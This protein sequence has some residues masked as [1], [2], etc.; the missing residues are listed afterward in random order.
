MWTLSGSSNLDQLEEEG[1]MT[2]FNSTSRKNGGAI[3]TAMGV[4]QVRMLQH[5]PCSSCA[6]KSMLCSEEAG[7]LSFEATWRV[8]SCTDHS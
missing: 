8:Q 5:A 3:S 6:L 7:L 2:F 1:I 4:Y